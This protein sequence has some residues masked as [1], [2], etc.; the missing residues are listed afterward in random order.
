MI[1]RERLAQQRDAQRAGKHF[2][3]QGEDGGSTLAL[4]LL[5]VARDPSSDHFVRL[6]PASLLDTSTSTA[7][8]CPAAMSITGTV[9]RVKANSTLSPSA[10]AISITSPAP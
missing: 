3:K 5:N 7:T 1:V 10:L 2:R 9:S 4:Q 6:E 8:I